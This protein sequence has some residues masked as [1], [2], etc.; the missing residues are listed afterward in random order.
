MRMP[1]ISSETLVV[2]VWP[3]LHEAVE[4]GVN[5]GWHRAYKYTETPEPEHIREQIHQA[6]MTELAERFDIVSES[7]S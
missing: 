6:V 4:A 3:V 2:K 1:K 7:Q 5:Y